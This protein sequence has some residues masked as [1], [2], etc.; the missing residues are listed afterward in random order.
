MRMSVGQPARPKTVGLL[1]SGLVNTVQNRLWQGAVK[2]AQEY[3]IR[4]VYYPTV[5]LSSIPPFNPQSKVLFDLVDAR[6]VDGLLIWYAGIAEGIGIDQGESVLE[7][8]KEIPLVTIGGGFKNYPNLSIT[9]EECT[10]LS[11]TL[12][13]STTTSILPSF[14]GQ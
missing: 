3:G 4:L 1:G 10:R 13:R 8:Y 11:S 9:I 12:L 7:R 2:A 5:S 14:V 6:Y